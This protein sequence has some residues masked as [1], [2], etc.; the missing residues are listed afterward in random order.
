MRDDFGVCFSD[1]LMAFRNQLMFQL[2]IVFDDSVVDYNDFAGAVAVGMRIFFRGSPVRG[3][4]CVANSVSS[5]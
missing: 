3:P 2:E 1:E 5:V 4:A